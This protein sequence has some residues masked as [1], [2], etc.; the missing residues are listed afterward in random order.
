MFTGIIETTGQ[1][2]S[3]R[4]VS[5]DVRL[6]VYSQSMDWQDVKLGDSIAVNGVCLT[7]VQLE[8]SLFYAD[9][10]LETLSC[11]SL[12]ALKM[13]HLV[14]LEKALQVSQRLGGHIVSGHVDGLAKVISIEQS[15]RS[16]RFDIEAPKALSHYIAIKGSVCLDGMSLTVNEIQDH[17][18]S[19]NI[20]P[21]TYQVTTVHQW[22]VGQIINLEVDL[23]ARYLERLLMKEQTAQKQID[24]SDPQV[25]SA[26]TKDFLANNGYLK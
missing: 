22:K 25:S 20:V 19:V 4:Q 3:L 6:A 1:L 23:I 24:Y 21:H 16:Y 15:A 14:N 26:I 7:V 5:G 9:V 8:P 18:F 11:T 12:S 10:S 13:G 2:R 17:L